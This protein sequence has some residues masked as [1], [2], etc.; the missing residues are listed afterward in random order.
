MIESTLADA[1]AADVTLATLVGQRIHH[2]KRPE[3]ETGNAIV[4][5]RVGT[6]PVVSLDGE[7]GLD[8][9]RMQIAA[10]AGNGHDAM[11]I[12]AAVRACIKAAPTLSGVP[13][14]QINNQVENTGHIRSIVDFNLWQRN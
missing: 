6:V 8:S 5:Q 10:I 3:N 2:L 1:L 14:M 12:I 13:V 4:F 11:Q 9:V 7:S